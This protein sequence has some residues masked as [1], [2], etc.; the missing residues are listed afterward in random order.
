MVSY[1]IGNKKRLIILIWRDQFPKILL[2]EPLPILFYSWSV[3]LPAR[4]QQEF[5][6]DTLKNNRRKRC[7]T[8]CGATLT[9]RERDMPWG[10]KVENNLG[11]R[12]SMCRCLAPGN[13]RLLGFP[14]PS[15][16]N[17]FKYRVYR[18]NSTP[19]A[20]SLRRSFQSS[21]FCHSAN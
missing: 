7:G 2:L 14:L 12:R 20:A 16:P 17:P 18:T 13:A 5:L 19:S 15:S 8:I 21:I 10:K 9:L 11:M 4:I 6:R 3:W 1:L